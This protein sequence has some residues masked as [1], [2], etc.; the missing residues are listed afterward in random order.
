LVFSVYVYAGAKLVGAGKT[1]LSDVSRD[2]S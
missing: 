1:S 2:F